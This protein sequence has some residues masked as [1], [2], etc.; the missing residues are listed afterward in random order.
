MVVTYLLFFLGIILLIKSA[1][2]LVR[3][4]SSL[5][6]KIHIPTIFIGITIVSIGTTMPELIVNILAAIKGVPE[7]A[8]GNILGS[9]MANIF[10]VLGITAI[11]TP[12]KI[13]RNAVWKEIPLALVAIIILFVVSNSIMIDGVNFNTIT[14]TS[15]IVMLLFFF[16]FIYYSIEVFKQ[17]RKKLEKQA[18][19]VK[20]KSNL[21]ITLMILG[22]VL[23]LYFGGKFTVDGAI[24]L[25]QQLG[26]SE[27]LISATIIAIGTSLPELTTGIIAARRKETGIVVGNVVGANIFNVFWILGVTAIIAPILVPSFINLDILIAGA[28]TI[29]LLIA[30]FTG[31]TRNIERW[32]GVLFLILYVAY[33]VFLGIRG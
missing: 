33:L 16:V 21:I 5:A 2:Y 4:S 31:K 19:G 15:G 24:L 14:R 32:E 26:I 29:I 9:I 3:G 27:F 23:G 10:L 11:I 18:I 7:I 20:K 8:F 13:E 25:A 17:T 12:I 30:V 22:G 1:D 28:A 6:E